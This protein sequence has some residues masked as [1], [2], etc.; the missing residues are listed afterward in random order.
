MKWARM[1]TKTS[2]HACMV[3]AYES[4]GRN[5]TNL[6]HPLHSIS[7]HDEIPDTAERLSRYGGET[8]DAEDF[9]SQAEFWIAMTEHAA[10]SPLKQA[11]AQYGFRAASLPGFKNE[12]MPALSIDVSAIDSRVTRLARALTAA[13]TAILTFNVMGTLYELTLDLRFRMGIASS[14]R[15]AS[16]GLA[17]NIPSGEAYIVP[18]EG[19]KIGKI[20]MT[21]G[22]LPLEFNGNLAL[23]EVQEN[24]IVCVDGDSTWANQLSESISIDPARANIAKLGLGILQDWNIAP[25]GHGLVDEKI[26]PHISIGRSEHIGGVTS[27]ADFLSPNNVHYQHYIF[28]PQLMPNITL[29]RAVLCFDDHESVFM[30]DNAYQF[31]DL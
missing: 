22:I 8:A 11:A 31:E 3:Y 18:Y 2:L 1:L 25:I 15:F 17:G 23:C 7:L 12:M 9:Y 19:E 10:T 16:N 5:N 26:A 28:H 21:G 29:A 13:H 30:I 4:L 20:S 24:H 27:P 14:G 6:I